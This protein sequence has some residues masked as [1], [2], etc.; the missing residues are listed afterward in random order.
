MRYPWSAI[1]LLGVLLPVTSLAQQIV[2]GAESAQLAGPDLHLVSPTDPSPSA[3]AAPP[4]TA[5]KPPPAE[6]QPIS[7]KP[8][9]TGFLKDSDHA[10]FT[11][12]VPSSGFYDLD[13][14]V[15]S[16]GTKGYAIAING[17]EI[18]GTISATPAHD[19][20]SQ[21]VGM[22]ELE[23]GSNVVRIN[24]GWGFFD[25]ASIQLTPS[26]GAL[27]VAKAP[28]KAVDAQITPEASALLSRLDTS[29][30]K[31]TLL[32]VYSDDDA[33]YVS[34]LTGVLPSIMGGDLLSYSPQEVA[35]GS[36]PERKDEVGRLIAR[37][38]AGYVVT[39]SWHWCSPAGLID[40]AEKPWWRGFYTDS[41]NFDLEKALADPT[42]TDY[43]TM[44]SDIDAIAVQLRKFQDAHVPILWRPLH[45]A[46]GGWFWWGAKG[47]KPFVKLW[48][49]LYDRLTD[50]D[51]I[52]N[53]IWVYTGDGNTAWYPGDSYVD[54]IGIDA[55]PKDLRD[56]QSQLWTAL[57]HNYGDRKIL[58][59]SEFGGT[60]DVP[61]MQK[62]GEFWSYAVSWSGKEGPKKNGPDDLKHIYSSPGVTTM[63]V[64]TAKPP[65]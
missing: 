34:D 59:I 31:T 7:G 29:Y 53:L 8:F 63:P 49:L 36:H 1:L 47:P 54:I 57:E 43:A 61:R 30:G 46:S 15:R 56:P 17:L 33:Q 52:H 13:L 2:V 40:S 37:S 62:M 23:K 35:H 16:A 25:V 19:F 39:L 51:G 60:P 55:Y 11:V 9:I 50:V 3:A 38:R 28:A 48:Q 6:V 58:A 27:R 44:L 10:D 12:K 14:D 22:V 20:V 21:R 64:T 41:T 18:S 5:A 45:E 42:S 26:D 4:V 65:S 24:K 32:G